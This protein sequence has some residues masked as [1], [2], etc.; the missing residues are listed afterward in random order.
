VI[1]VD[2]GCRLEVRI[3]QP[4]ATAVLIIADRFPARE[5]I[6]LVLESEGS[7]ASEMLTTN[8]DGHAVMA[9][10]PYVPGKAQGMLKATAEGPG[11]LPAVLLQWGPAHQ[12]ASTN[13]QL[14]PAKDE[15]KAPPAATPAATPAA[16][17][18]EAKDSKPGHTKK[19]LL[20]KLHMPG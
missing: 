3:A 9:V 7:S 12:A 16:A 2:K 13:P 8:A 11:C 15:R 14:E 18:A 4:D 5:R 10:F 1:S 19:S 17:P 6:P 20:H